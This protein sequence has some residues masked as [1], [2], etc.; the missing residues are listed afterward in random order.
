MAVRQAAKRSTGAASGTKPARRKAPPAPQTSPDEL[1][2]E[3]RRWLGE[4][5]WLS[6]AALKKLLPKAHHA[7][8]LGIARDLAARGDLYR[9]SK[10][11]MEHFFAQ[12]PIAKLETLVPALLDGEALATSELKEN[13]ERAAPGMSQLLPEWLKSAVARR[14]VFEH[15]P[16][17]TKPKGKNQKTY[18]LRPDLR[19]L[20]RKSLVALGKDLEAADAASIPRESVLEFLATA[21]SIDQPERAPS[22]ERAGGAPSPTEA[23]EPSALREPFLAALR[24]LAVKNGS[25]ALLSVRQLR[26]EAGIDKQAFDKTALALSR[27]GAVVLH[28]HDH[29]A[30]LPESE[31]SLLIRDAKGTHYV[32]I[33]LRGNS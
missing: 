29:P 6:A 20:L 4:A 16:P 9:Y 32:G 25:G 18:A 23:S 13:V 14:V 27:E 3:I 5:S 28:H 33:A 1:T 30:S 21:L 7:A 15:S 17:A 12:D 26:A 11:A 2:A 10:G 19:A 8:G 22:P 24:H 31:R